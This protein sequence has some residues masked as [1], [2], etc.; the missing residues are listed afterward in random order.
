[1]PVKKKKDSKKQP[2]P[3]EIANDGG[4]R[5][6]GSG[7]GKSAPLDLQDWLNQ[8]D[9][10]HTATLEKVIEKDNVIMAIANLTPAYTNNLSGE[11]TFA[12]RSR[13]VKQ[14]QRV[15]V[16]DKNNDLIIIFD[17]IN[18]YKASFRKKWL[19][20]S[21]QEPLIKNNFFEIN[22]PANPKT[23]M[24]GGRLKGQILL[25][26]KPLVNKIGGKGMEFY[27]D[28]INYDGKG[29]VLKIEQRKRNVEPGHWRLEVEPSA[30]HKEDLFL[31]A[32]Q[33]SLLENNKP[34]PQITTYKNGQTVYCEITGK[35]QLKITFAQDLSNSHFQS[36]F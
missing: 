6:I 29:Q 21:L 17:K 9:I 19:L 28:G 24:Q 12:H 10:Y 26:K 34:L 16:Y 14:Y 35:R 20:H 7:W 30:S 5:R 32:M 33:P 2:P 31:V 13:R 4:Q 3:R 25:P 15:L 27:I 22:T 36:G 11:G 1:M 8:S 18:A 23:R